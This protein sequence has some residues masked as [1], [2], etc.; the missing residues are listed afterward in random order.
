MIRQLERK[1]ELCLAI[2]LW[3]MMSKRWALV[4]KNLRKKGVYVFL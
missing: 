1:A 4:F 3:D 2:S